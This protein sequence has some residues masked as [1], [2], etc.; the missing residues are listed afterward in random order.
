M[1]INPRVSVPTNDP[2]DPD[3]VVGNGKFDG[4]VGI[5]NVGSIFGT[6]SLIH[7]CVVLTAAHVV[8][9][10]TAE[11]LRVTFRIPNPEGGDDI[12]VEYEVSAIRIH[13]D[14]DNGTLEHDIALV[15]LD[16]PAPVNGD[17]Y[18]LYSDTDELGET[19]TRVGYG[20]SGTGNLGEA[21]PGDDTLLRYGDN[22][23][24]ATDATHL[25]F[26]FDNGTEAS[27]SLEQD[28][29]VAD[30]DLGLAREIGTSGGDSGGPAFIDGVVAG[31]A[32]YGLEPSVGTDVVPGNN[33]S[34]GEIF[35]DTRVSDYITWINDQ[36]DDIEA[37]NVNVFK[38]YDA[39]NEE[40][41][42]ASAILPDNSQITVTDVSLT[43][44]T[45]AV[46]FFHA[47]DFGSNAKLDD[48]G[49]LL[50]SGD[51]TP[52]TSNTSSSYGQSNGTAG[53]ATLTAIA[54]A[55][56]EDAG[57]T[58]DAS[59]LTINFTVAAGVSAVSLDILFGSDEYP[60][61]SD[62]SFVDVGAV[63]VNGVNYGLFNNNPSQPL[64]IID[65]NLSAGNFIDNS[66]GGLPI[67]YDGISSKLTIT[68]PVTSGSN[69]IKIAVADTGDS[70]YDSG[71][72]AANLRPANSSSGGTFLDVPVVDNEATGTN[73]NEQF[74]G[75]DGNDTMSGGG[76]NDIM[77]GGS[78]N[79]EQWAG[80]G[81]DT[82]NGGDGDDTIGGGD[83]G[84]SVGGGNGADSMFGGGGGDN[85]AGGSGNDTAYGGNGD[86]TVK[87]EGDDDVIF[88][89]GASDFVSGGD[90]NDQAGGGAGD[91]EVYA[92]GGDD[93]VFGGDGSDTTYGG[94]GEDSVFGGAGN[95]TVGG[96]DGADTVNGGDGDD[97]VYGGAGGDIVNG[98]AGTDIIYA[99]P[100]D[101]TVNG[102]EGDDIVYGGPGNDVIVLGLNHGADTIGGFDSN[103]DDTLDLSALGLSGIG[104]LTFTQNGNAVE[105]NT[106]Q[107]TVTFW[108][109]QVSD[110]TS[111]D[112]IF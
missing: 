79:D 77:D 20:T 54:Q 59:I 29:Y 33:T 88:G 93:T 34:F 109:A 19:F 42:L 75:G 23:F 49:I 5:G 81:N 61:Y 31:V 107:A 111:E 57:S 15:V 44:S 65:G 56:F 55:A 51:G 4:V 53:D 104:D 24:E 12:E 30:S 50:T 90:G 39:E 63:L 83:G 80:T 32:S 94:D 112:F 102:G 14:Y 6:G 16:R 95:D 87:G 40:S 82:V 47:V 45:S 43:G 84:D 91:D 2:D 25:L 110:F 68:A 98:G 37:D 89:S 73:Q 96:G 13:E 97:E 8:E 46:S 70:V 58:N 28:G 35:G 108:N 66:G 74:E 9:G 38:A 60:E 21:A 1:N 105:M 67:E 11:N 86:D 26:D 100:G 64:S 92:G 18:E 52:P 3:F 85:V 10:E 41:D 101:D 69:T 17:R 76:G 99:S 48:C 106:G 78:G 62:S 27:N 7:Q 72:F 103:G 36:M 22:V 71:I